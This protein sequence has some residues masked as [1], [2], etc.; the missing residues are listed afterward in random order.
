MEKQAQWLLN[1]LEKY[2]VD[3]GLSVKNS[4]D[5]INKIKGVKLKRGE[6][7][8]SFDVKNLF[9]N[10]PADKAIDCMKRHLQNK[11][12][13]PSEITACVEIAR[14][15]MSQNF[16]QFRGRYY[17]QNFGLS[18]GSKLSPYLAN[19]FMSEFEEK[20]KGHKMFPRL[21][22]RYVDD[23]FSIVK[24]RYIGKVL[25]LINEQ[26]QTIKFTVE[27]ENDGDLPFL[28]ILISRGDNNTIE[29]SI[30]RKPTHTDRYITSDSHHCGG[31]K[32]AAFHSMVHR[33]FTTPM[34]A[35]KLEEEK[36]YIYEVGR[37]NGYPKEF[38]GKIIKK[39][40]NKKRINEATSLE[41]IND[42]PDRRISVPYYPVLT[43]KLQKTL[44]KHNIQLVTTSSTTL[45]NNI[46]NYKDQEEA[47]KSSGI[48]SIGCKDCNSIY[49]GQTRR[50][51]GKR[52]KEH[53]RHANSGHVEQSSVAEHMVDLG[54]NIDNDSITV[55]KRV[56]KNHRLDAW[57]SLYI[58]THD[59][60]LM[61]KDDIP[62]SSPLF[63]LT[64]LK[65]F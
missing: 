29:F 28:D 7:L 24:E 3:F 19:I 18:M 27:I 65:N 59:S 32:Q 45:Q 21:W 40:G 36:A 2:P 43:N 10:I 17:K 55:L 14:V 38:V 12:A 37:L 23:I 16:F 8:V 6:K 39:H 4:A 56:Q 25:E 41:P 44:N 53:I 11:R 58:S 31:H 54:H 34:R 60:P 49:I 9:P 64:S 52:T 61:N 47:I 30:Y 26:H 13:P 63:Y 46:C 51:I 57:E 1:T 50:K 20:L 48:Y 42:P 5:L 33:M 15:C 35:E 62:I 22:F